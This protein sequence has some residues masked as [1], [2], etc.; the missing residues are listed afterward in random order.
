MVE[1]RYKVREV[2]D[3]NKI[4]IFLKQARI[5]YLEWLT[6]ICLMLFHLILFGQMG[7]CIST[8][9]LAEDAIK[10]WMK[11]RKSALQYV[12]NME[13]LRSSARKDGHCVY[14]CYRFWEGSTHHRFG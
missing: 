14:E 3:Q 5:G 6:V 4:D 10:L 9:L 13:R 11:I 12:K 1:V 2:L 7:C 8:E